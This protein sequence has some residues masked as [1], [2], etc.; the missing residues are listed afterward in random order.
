MKLCPYIFLLVSVLWPG[1]M[2]LCHYIVLPVSVLWAVPMKLCTVLPVSV[3]WASPWN[4]VLSYQSECCGLAH[5]T[6]SLY[7]LTSLSA[8]R[9]SCLP[10]GPCNLVLCT[11][12]AVSHICISLSLL[13]NSDEQI[14]GIW[15]DIPRPKK[16]LWPCGS[17]YH[18]VQAWMLPSKFKFST[19]FQIVSKAERNMFSSMAH[20]L[21]KA[22]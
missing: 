4:Y 19:I 16:G 9:P 12:L 3:L 14:W 1:L 22:L 17:Q 2:K 5:E 15:R 6:M 18:D 20:I 8:V 13:T 10:L 11:T 7:Y 21:L